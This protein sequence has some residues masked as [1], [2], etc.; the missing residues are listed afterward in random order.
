MNSL[1]NLVFT[2]FFYLIDRSLINLYLEN[3]GSGYE[4]S[5]K[6]GVVHAVIV[7]NK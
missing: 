2:S 4:P 5:L 1:I 3:M 7:T 6:F